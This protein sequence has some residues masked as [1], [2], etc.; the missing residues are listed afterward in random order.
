MHGV[1]PAEA[2]IF[3]CFHT[4]R[5]ILFLL[6]RIVITLFTFCTSQCYPDAHNFHLT[7]FCRRTSSAF[8]TSRITNAVRKSTHKKKACA[9]KR[10]SILT[11]ASGCVKT[12]LSFKYKFSSLFTA[13]PLMPQTSRAFARLSPHTRLLSVAEGSVGLI[14][15]PE[16]PLMCE[17]NGIVPNSGWAVNSNKKQAKCASCLSTYN[18]SSFRISPSTRAAQASRSARVTAP[19]STAFCTRSGNPH[20]IFTSF[21]ARIS[22]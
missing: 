20:P 4:I 10:L 11:Q 9:S 5:M 1:L 19:R 6:G 14:R 18:Q 2:A 22:L 21:P 16:Q 12:I 3:L 8:R 17:H 7:L 13:P 15:N